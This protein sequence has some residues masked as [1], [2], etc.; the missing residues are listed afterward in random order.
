MTQISRDKKFIFLTIWGVFFTVMGVFLFEMFLR[1]FF[2]PPLLVDVRHLAQPRKVNEKQ[3]LKEGGTLF[4]IS[5]TGRRL[6]PNSVAVISNR[7]SS[8]QDVVIKTNSLGYRNPEIEAKTKPRVLF[9]G[10]SIT[11]A[12]TVDEEDSF[13]RRVEAL[14]GESDLPIETVNAG[15]GAIGLETYWHILQETGLK[16]DPDL[17]VVG[18]YLNDFQSSRMLPLFQPPEM[19]QWSWAANY[20]F[21]TFSKRFA[22]YTRDSEQWDDRIPRIPK[23]TLNEW[24]GFVDCCFEELEPSG[25]PSFEFKELVKAHMHDWGGAWS[26][27]AWD[28]MS[29][30]LAKMK[31]R[32][33]EENISLAIIMF[34]VRSQVEQEA[35]LNFPQRRAAGIAQKLGVPMLDLLPILRQEWRKSRQALFFDHCHYSPYGHKVLSPEIVEFVQKTLKKDGA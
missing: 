3:V 1:L 25:V 7:G 2:P 18:L 28:K 12:D 27:G 19:L 23:E 31:Q 32:L 10:D 15:V 13:V 26:Y 21:H 33:D 11:F 22:D 17:V 6:R 9:L 20:L 34:P 30:I 35:V 29:V 16:T 14:A 5:K 8:N 4:M 24:E